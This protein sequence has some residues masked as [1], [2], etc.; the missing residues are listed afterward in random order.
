MGIRHDAVY[1][2]LSCAHHGTDAVKLENKSSAIHNIIIMNARNAQLMYIHLIM[3]INKRWFILL[4]SEQKA[5][6]VLIII[7]I[8][9]T[10]RCYYTISTFIT[11]RYN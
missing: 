3:Y 11:M 4:T 1:E 10:V 5:E 6:R 8:I 9:I 7:I 2:Y